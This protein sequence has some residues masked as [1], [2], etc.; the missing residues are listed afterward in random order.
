MSYKIPPFY[1]LDHAVGPGAINQRFDVMLVQFFLKALYEQAPFKQRSV[2]GD[3]K[4]NGQFDQ[5]T[6]AHILDFQTA[7]KNAGGLVFVDGRV[8]PA[9]GTRHYQDKSS[10]SKTR[11]TIAKL[12][13]S[14][15]KRFQKE[16]DHLEGSKRVPKDLQDIL[17]FDEI[18]V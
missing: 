13:G 2:S 16:H 11:Y 17:R 3:I 4:V 12:N 6:A 10:I 14:F 9:K 7:N 18:G 5:T 1:N 15:R 8:D